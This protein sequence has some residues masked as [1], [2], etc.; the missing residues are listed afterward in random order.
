MQIKTLA[1]CTLCIV[2]GF[3]VGRM[4]PSAESELDSS[5]GEGGANSARSTKQGAVS[6]RAEARSGRRTRSDADAAVLDSD[7]GL[8]DPTRDG[9]LVV[10]PA[11]LIGKLSQ[12]AGTRSLGQS[13]FTQSGEIEQYLQITDREKKEVQQAWKAVQKEMRQYESNA[14]QTEDLEDGSVKIT[15]PDM[16]LAMRGF[17]KE[18]NESVQS[19]LGENRAEAFLQ[20]KQADRILTP[21]E[22][23]QVYTVKVEAVGD[24]R[25]R[26]HMAV[27]SPSGRRVW[28]GENVPEELRHLTDAAKINPEMNPDS[29]EDS[30]ED[31]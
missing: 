11:S 24:G 22:G 29:G 30:D 4:M 14:A 6:G 13:L 21:V 1:A 15:V 18:F 20:M 23:D 27:E 3:V 28:V 12:S 9:K 2:G 26:Y 10:V 17:G 16:S 19:S 8:I 5:A 7:S 25:W 31:E